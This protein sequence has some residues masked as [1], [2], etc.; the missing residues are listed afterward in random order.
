MQ[1]G[2]FSSFSF[3]LFLFFS[4]AGFGSCLVGVYYF[5][6]SSA[7]IS[8]DRNELLSPIEFSSAGI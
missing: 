5:Y 3:L 8:A 2:S 4:K 6:E 1:F 7:R